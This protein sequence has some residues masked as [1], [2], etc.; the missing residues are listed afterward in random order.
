MDVNRRIKTAVNRYC[1]VTNID[2]EYLERKEVRL[3]ADDARC[4]PKQVFEWLDY[5]YGDDDGMEEEC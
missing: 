3:I 4:K 2:P 1:S 5:W